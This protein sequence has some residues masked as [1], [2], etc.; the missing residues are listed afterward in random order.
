MSSDGLTYTYTLRKGVKW[1]TSDGE[2][3]ADVKA[4]DFVTGLKHAADKKGDALYIVQDSIK[5]LSDYIEGKEKDFSL[6][7]VKALDDYTVQYT[8][9]KPESF[10]NSKLTYSVL[11]PLNADFLKAQGKKFG[12]QDPSSILYNGAFLLKSLTSK[13]VIEMEKNQN[14]WDKKNIKID[15]IKLTYY[16]GSNT[17]TLYK[18]FD[19][20][21]YLATPI[22]PTKPIF[23]EIEKK[24][25]NNI[26]Y[27]IQD[28]TTYYGAFNLNRSAYEFTSK[29]SDKEKSD[30]KAAILNKS[31]RQAVNFGINRKSYNAQ[32]NGEVAAEY[33][34]RNIIVPPTFVST[35]TKNFGD[36]VTEELKS[37][38]TEWSDVNLSDAQDGLY[39]KDKAKAAIQK[40]RTELEAEGVSFPIHLDI[41][42]DAKDDISLQ[43]VSSIKE[44]IES[45]LGNDNVIVDL[46]KLSNANY[47][48]VTYFAENAEQHDFDISFASGWGSDYLDPSTYLD[49]FNAKNGAKLAAI[50]LSSTTNPDI[51]SKIGL[52][53]YTELLNNASSISDNLDSRYEAYAKAQAWLTDSS[54][55]L[56]TTSK[57][58]TP[59]IS[60]VVPFS[61]V[62]ALAGNKGIEDSFKFFEFQDKPVTTQQ[63]NKAKEKWLKEK[64]ESNKKYKED[65]ANHIE[66]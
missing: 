13:S 56:P 36:L 49:I 43:S 57:G 26:T 50:G 48:R 12:T 28:A 44:S 37:Y 8:L 52:D 24:Y 27:G 11:F 41:P 30:T 62:Y 31:F 47:E 5:G 40:A 38:G 9:N 15:S 63:Y 16:D 46:Q 66:K 60:K 21:T 7:G 58:G 22:F 61:G 35:S 34:L 10:W 29:S 1:Y 64:A 65:L 25:G 45:T 32:S 51:I 20:G 4:Q 18:G 19:E 6:V 54:I 39:N 23:K 55:V 14:Y 53:Q 17:D 42:I 3:Y 33:A 59:R 2:E